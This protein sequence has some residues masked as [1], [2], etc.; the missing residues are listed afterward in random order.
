MHAL[1]VQGELAATHCALTELRYTCASAPPLHL[2]TQPSTTL[3][4]VHRLPL[5]IHTPLGGQHVLWTDRR[6]PKVRK[7]HGRALALVRVQ[8]VLRLDIPA[9]RGAGVD[10]EVWRSCL[11]KEQ[12]FGLDVPAGMACGV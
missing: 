1:G 6:Q 11:E 7:L 10:G 3:H 9:G 12:A 8:Q 4:L 2:H 5:F